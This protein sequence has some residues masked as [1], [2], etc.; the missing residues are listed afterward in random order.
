MSR[1]RRSEKRALS[2]SLFLSLG[3]EGEFTHT[4]GFWSDPTKATEIYIFRSYR[5]KASGTHTHTHTTERGQLLLR[6]RLH[7]VAG[8]S[9]VYFVFFLQRNARVCVHRSEREEK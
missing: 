9:T 4:D 5:P 3:E 7:D 2:L 1:D 8:Q 6:D